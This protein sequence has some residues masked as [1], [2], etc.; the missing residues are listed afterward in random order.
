MLLTRG[1]HY[2]R[3]VEIIAFTEPC[4]VASFS[5]KLLDVYHNILLL[6]LV[7]NIMNKSKDN[8]IA[9]RNI[10]HHQKLP[11]FNLLFFYPSAV[12][13]KSATF[14]LLFTPRRTHKEQRDLFSTWR[15]G[16]G[17]KVPWLLSSVLQT[18]LLEIKLQ[19]SRK[20][21]KIFHKKREEDENQV[22]LLQK[23]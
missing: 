21:E 1:M 4:F 16:Q 5:W 22:H 12:V 9:H 14:L 3:T 6:W 18:Q 19:I 23:A 10:R 20:K 11:Q 8:G 13:R 15:V 7:E 2:P 17:I